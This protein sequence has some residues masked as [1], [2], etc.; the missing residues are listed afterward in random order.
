MDLRT[1]R[2]IL[3]DIAEAADSNS[4]VT[5]VTSTGDQVGIR[6]VLPLYS[7]KQIIIRL[8]SSL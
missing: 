7:G 5:V 6:S 3:D 4:E 8:R 1:L 2:T